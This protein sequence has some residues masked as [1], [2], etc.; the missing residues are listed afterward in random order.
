MRV[1]GIEASCPKPGTSRANKH[2]KIYP[3]LLKDLKI[4]KPNQVWAHEVRSARALERH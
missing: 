4:D 1:M 3:Y 2:H